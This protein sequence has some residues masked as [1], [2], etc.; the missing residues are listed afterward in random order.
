[1]EAVSKEFFHLFPFL[2]QLLL[3]PRLLLRLLLHLEHS[4]VA[5]NSFHWFG[6]YRHSHLNQLRF[7]S[8]A[9][10]SSPPIKHKFRRLIRGMKLFAPEKNSQVSSLMTIQLQVPFTYEIFEEHFVGRR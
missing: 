10:F 8:S 1:M 5:F 9:H 7:N 3:L 4:F 6:S 2:L